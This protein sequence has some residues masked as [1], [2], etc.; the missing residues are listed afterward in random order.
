[1]SLNPEI[2]IHRVPA[3]L[4]RECVE[5]PGIDV[6]E[7]TDF[8]PILVLD[9]GPDL[10]DQREAARTGDVPV[11]FVTRERRDRHAG[12]RPDVIVIDF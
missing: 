1:M 8:D 10:G 3:G 12:D 2:G 9:A 5:L 11:A 4:R 6:N 7:I